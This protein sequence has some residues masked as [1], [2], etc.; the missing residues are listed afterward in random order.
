MRGENGGKGETMA[1]SRGRDYKLLDN[2]GQKG[3]N[4]G[5]LELA[6]MDQTR[7]GAT[8]DLMPGAGGLGD[9]VKVSTRIG[10][11]A[12]V[13]VLKPMGSNASGGVAQQPIGLK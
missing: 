3:G 9:V 12:T 4:S 8:F 2:N 13:I 11:T 5:L 7:G 1:Q 10:N 6:I